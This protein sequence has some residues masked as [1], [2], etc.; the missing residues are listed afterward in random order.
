MCLEILH[1]VVGGATLRQA[2]RLA[3]CNRQ[4]LLGC[5]DTPLRPA[6]ICSTAFKSSAPSGQART[7]GV[8]FAPI[9][10]RVGAIRVST[11]PPEQFGARAAI[12]DALADPGETV[13]VG[14]AGKMADQ[15]VTGRRAELAGRQ[16]AQ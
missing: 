10:L 8:R 15:R 6:F 12:D 4:Q 7:G 16:S 3:C 2:D 14:D 5:V 13:R 11:E 9:S 1:H